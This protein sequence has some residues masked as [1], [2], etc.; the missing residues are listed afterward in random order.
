MP[1]CSTEVFPPCVS[2]STA[3]SIFLK[4]TVPVTGCTEPAAIA[5]ATALS[6]QAARGHVPEWLRGGEK[7]APAALTQDLEVELVSVRTVR[8]LYKNA[9][10]VGIPNSEG[11]SGIY[12][13]AALGPFVDP[14]S[15]LNL[16]KACGPEALGL[17]RQLLGAKRL[18]LEVQ[19]DA[20]EGIF[21]EARLIGVVGGQRHVG[22]AVI[23]GSHDGVVLVRRD[24][25]VLFEKER[26]ES[27]QGDDGGIQRLAACDLKGLVAAAKNL[28]SQAR[29]HLRAGVEMN[30]EAARVGLSSAFGLGVGAS[31]QALIDE[32]QLADDMPTRASVLT[33]AATDARMSGHEI[34]VMSSSGSGNQGI[35]TVLPLV[36]VAEAKGL[37]ASTLE[38]A[39]A[40]SHLV[41]AVMTHHAG[42]LSPLCGCVVKA[43]MGAA[44]GIAVA[45]G[46][47]ADGV[48]SSLK[49]MAGNMTGEICDGA[50]V[51]C[52]IKLCAAARAAVLSALFASRGI[53]IP[54]NN[55]I[56]A[57]SGRDLFRNIGDLA[58]SMDEVD[59]TIVD[60]MER[61]Q[62]RG[63]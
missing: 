55:G 15:G 23:T 48:L 24:G 2:P 10:A 58:R 9:L 19:G 3:E 42:L 46:L 4:A 44:A 43:G 8:S 14:G 29:A 62:V 5:L 50:K 60:I 33:A 47:D 40:V 20:R 63:G 35:M 26:E 11:G 21:V 28:T 38:E 53:S 52:A 27:G 39:V 25:K 1:I 22:E 12:L 37:D 61:K 56:L 17:A 32:G 13:A 16:L 7:R 51:G 54:P 6:A 49:N 59:E 45:L 57:S 36:A 30:R 18:S 31:L 41:T 34:E